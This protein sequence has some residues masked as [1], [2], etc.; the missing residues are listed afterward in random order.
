MAA[1]LGEVLWTTDLFMPSY[2]AKE[3]ENWRILDGGQLGHDWGYVSGPVMLQI[4]PSLLRR[5]RSPQSKDSA[6]WEI[7]M[8][9]TPHEIESQELGC[10]YAYGHVVVMG[11]G[12]GW[13]AANMV[14]NVNVTKVTVVDLDP[15]VIDLFDLSGAFDSLPVSA[16]E[17][18]EIVNAD[19]TQWKPKVPGSVDFLYA[20]IWFGLAEP[21]ALDQVRQMQ[22]NIQAQIVY[23]WGQEIAIYS[24]SEGELDAKEIEQV[25]Q[26][27]IGLPLLVPNDL[28]YAEM[29]EK[30]IQNRIQRGRVIK[31]EV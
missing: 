17:K 18:I 14:L 9:L 20:D 31:V 8:S 12:M 1:A 19:A 10:R 26:E 29:I 30:V 28:N 3:L 6:E 16:Q 13:I 24:A 27:R 11:L 2:Q 22:K 15:E 23:Y 7:W 4:L 25:V 5:V 21:E